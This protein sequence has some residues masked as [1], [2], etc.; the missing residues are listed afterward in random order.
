M[1]ALTKAAH[2][3]SHTPDRHL[4]HAPAQTARMT[5]MI[6]TTKRLSGI[7]FVADVRIA[8]KPARLSSWLRLKAEAGFH[9]GSSYRN[10]PAN[11]LHPPFRDHP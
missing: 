2:A 4:P 5:D 6:P 11:V 9:A 8:L 1:P 7:P 3:W 10:S